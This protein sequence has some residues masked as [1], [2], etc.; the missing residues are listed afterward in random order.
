MN[1]NVFYLV[2]LYRGAILSQPFACPCH[3]LENPRVGFSETL[4]ILITGSE[5]QGP[6]PRFTWNSIGA[7]LWST[8]VSTP[9]RSQVTPTI[10][11]F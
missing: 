3:P 8:E 9:F 2:N 4:G 11:I 6:S 10:D 7:Y 5:K 1:M